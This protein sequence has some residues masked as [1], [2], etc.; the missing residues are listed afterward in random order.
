MADL[1][2][3][4]NKCLHD[5]QRLR[6]R[7]EKMAPTAKSRISIVRCP[8]Y[9]PPS[10]K[11]A[12]RTTIDLLGG[13]SRFVQNGQSVLIKP[14]MLSPHPPAKA[15]TT[16]PSLVEGVVE[17]VRAAGGIPSVG[18]S[19]GFYKFSRVAEVSGIGE[20]ARRAGAPL[21]PFEEEEEIATAKGCLMK[22]LVVARAAA[23]TGGIISL[24]KFKTHNLTCVTAAI[25]N[26]FGCIP[27]LKKA[28]M[29]FRFSDVDR[30]SHMLADIARSLPARLHVL[31]AIVGMDGDGP[32]AG[33]P[34]R[35]GLIIAGA[36]PVAVDSTACRIVGIDPLIIP[37]IRVASERGV[38]N[39]AE[40][41]IETAGESI[42][43]VRVSGF[44]YTPPG[45]TG[46]HLPIPGFLLRRL[47]NWIVLKPRTLH[48]VCTR[49]GACVEICPARP[50]AL[51]LERGR[52]RID[53]RAC[54]LCYCCSE[55]CPSRAIRLRRGF[56]AGILAKLLKIS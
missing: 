45:G 10:V 8:S 32:A 14:N 22:R 40:E 30:F 25:K 34:F 31:D 6:L 43:R 7:L 18:D 11:A 1:C 54:I 47:K 46:P 21:V 26:L 37:M 4:G 9:D 36:D 38:G 24:P 52:I 20:A 51:S 35:M 41:L 56:A 29:H 50:K 28:E 23:S 55:I 17:L 49:C 48:D 3:L 15:V 12:L 44:R 53:D 16:H 19:P 27:G 5:S 39:A 42:E 2:Y 13:M 33:E